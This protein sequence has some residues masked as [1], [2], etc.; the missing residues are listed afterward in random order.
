MIKPKKLNVGDRIAMVSPSW[1]GPGAF[2]WV[3]E[4]G[5]R[6]TEEA[7]GVEFVEM[8]HARHDPDWLYRHP[9]AR[10]ED[11]MQAFADPSIKAI[12]STVGGDESIRILPF[13]DLD[14]I[15]RNPKIFLGFSDMTT[16]HLACYRAGLVS[17][18]G[19]SVMVEL[20]ESGGIFPYTLQA[21]KRTLFGSEP[22]GKIDASMSPWTGAMPSWV[23]EDQ[24]Q[25]REVNPPMPWKLLQGT[26]TVSG[27]LL[28]GCFEALEFVKGTPYWP[29]LDQWDGSILFLE[30]Y[31]APSTVYCEHWLRNYAS[32][33]I[34]QR[35]KGILFGRPGGASLKEKDVEAYDAAFLKITAE[36]GLSDL[37]I[38]SRMDFGHTDPKFILPYG[39]SA[40]LRCEDAGLVIQENAVV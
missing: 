28:G 20:A 39:I 15:K 9:Q 6:Q 24:Q 29:S 34:L 40:E 3:Y 36:V 23:S 33:G 18:Y 2:P 4:L 27:H 1:G 19:P 14:I 7:L 31:D 21:I 13:L 17:F 12:F 5:K 38:L 37:P 16:I 22:V 10:A 30:T 32:Q 25:K 11:L 26:G 35:A 8:P